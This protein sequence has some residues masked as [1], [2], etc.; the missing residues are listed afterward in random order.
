MVVSLWRLPDGARRYSFIQVER[1]M[2]DAVR[3]QD[4]LFSLARFTTS[5]GSAA[6]GCGLLAHARRQSSHASSP[7]AMAARGDETVTLFG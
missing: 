6:A 1:R 3:K 5:R 2:N 7:D 4:A